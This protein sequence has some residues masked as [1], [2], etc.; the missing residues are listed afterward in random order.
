MART[1]IIALVWAP[2]EARTESFAQ[3]LEAPLYNIHYF[4][5]KRP[6]IAPL[7]YIFQW[8]KTWQVLLQTRPRYVYVTNSPPVAGLCVMSYCLLT[9]TEFIMDTHPPGL[10]NR[11]WRWSRPIQRFTARFA[12]LNVVDQERFR[13]LFESWGAEAI[14]LENPPKSIPFEQ[15]ELDTGAQDE[16][17]YIGTFADDEP[18]EILIE[19]ARRLPDIKVYI[20][21]DKARA[22]QA[23]LDGAP[24]NI[25]FTG[26]LLKD[27]Y[28]NRLYNARAVIVL[29][30]HAHSLLGGA[31][32]GLYI[33]KP[34]I[35]SDQETLREHFV[36]G[37][38][39]IENTTQGMVDGIEQ[40]RQNETI[41]QEE[42][43]ALRQELAERWQQ[44]FGQLKAVVSD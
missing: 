13:Q 35:I 40:V 32:D 16:F 29:T 36:K 12:K 26:Y 11:K 25:I 24:E 31:Q 41:L 37:A 43:K 20:L 38:V 1:P 6:L 3:W 17:C 33:D 18:V 44:N 15:L 19:A 10:F 4:Q 21:G 39:F 22:K 23:W 34:L 8:L 14:V 27:E 30:E 42:I 7:K 9:D 5:A 2:H 28:W